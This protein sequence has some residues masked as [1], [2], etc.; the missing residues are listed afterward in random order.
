M[1]E[2][3]VPMSSKAK[4]KAKREMEE[5]FSNSLKWVNRVN[6]ASRG[7]FGISSIR[8]ELP[9]TVENPEAVV[10]SPNVISWENPSMGKGE[11]PPSD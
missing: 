6:R 7:R 3:E 8:M 1:S 2:S 9:G 10:Q 4:R 11:R 5:R